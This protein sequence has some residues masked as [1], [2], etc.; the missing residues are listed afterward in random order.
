MQYG[1][2][3]SE[4]SFNKR[5]KCHTKGVTRKGS[6]EA[7]NN[8]DIYGH[9]FSKSQ[10]IYDNRTTHFFLTIAEHVNNNPKNNILMPDNIRQKRLTILEYFYANNC[11]HYQPFYHYIQKI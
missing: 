1:I 2:V 7:S 5:L 3:K 8:L 6:I 11:H 9:A 4:I 10:E